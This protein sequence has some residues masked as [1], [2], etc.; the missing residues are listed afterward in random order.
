VQEILSSYISACPLCLF[1]VFSQIS[2][3]YPILEI[4]AP[5]SIILLFFYP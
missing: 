3:Y 4:I 2:S 1:L 5:F